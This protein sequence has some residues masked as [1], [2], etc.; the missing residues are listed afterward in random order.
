MRR[1]RSA[2]VLALLVRG[3]PAQGGTPA[4]PRVPRWQYSSG[5]TNIL[6][7]A[8]RATFATEADYLAFPLHE[9]QRWAHI[10]AR[11]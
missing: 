2:T 8:L 7:R 1:V 11:R 4:A 5:T 3:I 9:L 10:I 6:C